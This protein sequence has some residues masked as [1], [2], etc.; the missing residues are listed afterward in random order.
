M[1]HMKLSSRQ[2]VHGK[3]HKTYDMDIPLNR[4]L[5]SSAA[6]ADTKERLMRSRNA[7]DIVKLSRRIEEASERLSRAYEKNLRRLND[8]Q[9]ERGFREI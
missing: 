6:D 8:A 3:A 7:T 4:V 2:R 9:T 5:K 1:P